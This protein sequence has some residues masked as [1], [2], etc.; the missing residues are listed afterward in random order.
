MRDAQ[1]FGQQIARGRDAKRILRGTVFEAG[2]GTAGVELPDG[3]R[4]RRVAT[5]GALSAGDVVD[6]EIGGNGARVLT[7]GEAHAGNSITSTGGSGG[8]LTGAPSPHDLL[9]AHHTL[10]TLSANLFLASLL[11][12]TGQPSFRAIGPQDLPGQFNGFGNPSATVGLTAKNGTATTAMR[13]DGAPA[14]D[15]GITPTWTGAHVFSNTVN[16]NELLAVTKTSEQLRL[17]YNPS[18]Y[19]AFT[20][21]S[22]GNLTVA[23]TGDFLFDPVGNDILP[24][25]NYDLNLGSLSKKY[26]TLHAAEL[27]VETLVAQDTIATIGGRVLVAPTTQLTRDLSSS[28]G[29][30]STITQR[31]SATTAN[32]SSSSTAITYVNSAT[33]YATNT[34]SIN[35]NVPAGTQEGH[36]MLAVVNFWG[37]L[38]LTA[39]GGWTE[40][41]TQKVVAGGGEA[42]IFWRIASSSEPASYT[43]S[44]SFA[45]YS[46]AY[47]A[48]YAGVDVSAPVNVSAIE[49]NTSST[50]AAQTAVTTTAANAM[51][52][53][54]LSVDDGPSA[55][56][57]SLTTTPPSG[58]TERID[59][60]SGWKCV[61]LAEVLQAS[62]G[63]TGTKTATLSSAFRTVTALVALKPASN[64]TQASV[65]KP[66]G[67]TTGDVLIFAAAVGG[68]S[69][70]L[71]TPD[72]LTLAA[73][74]SS[75]TGAVYWYYKIAGG[76]E[77]ANYAF[78]L[79]T[80]N[81]LVLSCVAYYNVDTSSPIEAQFAT[82][83]QSSTSMT[84][85]GISSASTTARLIFTGAALGSGAGSITATAP[86]GMTELVDAGTGTVRI[87]YAHQAL[88]A[89]G[90][91][92]DKTATL[93]SAKPSIVGLFALK[94]ATT[95][96]GG[97]TIY[98]KHNQMQ[99]GDIVYMQAN[100]KVEWMAITS[101]PTT[102]TAGAEYSYTVTRNLDGTGENTW[103]AGDAIANTGTRDSGFIDLYSLESVKG[104]PLDHIYV[105]NGSA[106]GAN[107]AQESSFAFRGT[108]PASGTITYYGVES[109]PF[110]AFYHYLQTPE[111]H[112]GGNSVVEYWNGS[113]W[114][115]VPG[116]VNTGNASYSVAGL[117][118]RTWNPAALT[119]WAKTTINGVS[120]Y[121]IRDRITAGTWTRAGLQGQRRVYRDKNT[122]GP[123]IAGMVRNS[124]TF[125]DIR[126]RW[127]IGN[128]N[129]LYDYG[130]NT[131]GAAFGNPLTSWLGIDATNG[132][133]VM[134]GSN[135]LGRWD[136]SG[137]ITIGNSTAAHTYI[138][139]G[140]MKMR[141]GASDVITLSSGANAYGEIA[142]FDGVIGVS[143][144]GAFQA[145]Y[146][147]VVLDDTGYSQYASYFDT[148]AVVTPGDTIGVPSVTRELISLKT[149]DGVNAE[150]TTARV[151]SRLAFAAGTN[152]LGLYGNT[153]IPARSVTVI[154]ALKPNYYHD[155]VLLGTEMTGT[156]SEV[157]LIADDVYVKGR[158]NVTNGFPSGIKVPRSSG[159]SIFALDASGTGSTFTLANNATLN[160]FGSTAAVGLILISNNS[161]GGTALVLAN[162]FATQIIFD[163]SNTFSA[164]AGT[165]NKNNVY[166]TTIGNPVV[167]ENKTGSSSQYSVM[168]LRLA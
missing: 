159:T 105:Y 74:A 32:G 22:G 76:S 113:A 123:T 83:G 24:V 167:V 168:A 84:A 103:N 136:T 149:L 161:T 51:V 54:V 6:V 37:D 57:T 60:A 66:T 93:S 69:A 137:N 96:G 73:S 41:H 16:I 160:L 146:G 124:S 141:N 23:P 59:F 158:L 34:T 102:V 120:A 87:Y 150:R 148:A 139:A 36:F 101:A 121:W 75:A 152:G 14:L 111:S 130:A 31:G 79:D 94:P 43:W 48:T 50:S 25:T 126:E 107:M 42:R 39:P 166:K 8:A 11:S 134:N 122:W 112:T 100:G 109:A 151:Y 20:V 65:T 72:G 38:T 91:T 10:P 118:G 133:R 64:T 119:G 85:A 104:I 99:A 114:A 58:M 117:T 7:A 55:P 80:T 5:N 131:Y 140:V 19:A 78:S 63:T 61:Y 135:V 81:D 147:K 98:V 70:R 128:L 127:A 15:V 115:T 138:S 18:N 21:D 4:L 53:Y 9:G 46:M 27:W 26:L 49:A 12:G 157:H 62:A 129:G 106:F 153:N 3:V 88:S 30:E 67:V 95:G 13:S 89:A 29:S 97:Q 165:A 145:G 71:I 110:S 86:S 154:E 90:L 116:L 56:T 156:T 163:P 132:V 17:R 125:N 35:V 47:I 52:L 92:G 2:N 1:S 40:L 44:T 162:F 143:A 144:N 155:L 33:T 108:S 142:T 164:A 28:A 82:S 68:S 77:P 45:D